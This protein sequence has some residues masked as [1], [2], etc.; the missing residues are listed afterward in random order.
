MKKKINPLFLSTLFT[1]GIVTSISTVFVPKALASCTDRGLGSATATYTFSAAGNKQVWLRMAGTTASSKRINVETRNANGATSCLLA[2]NEAPTT[3]WRWVRA[4]GASGQF[5]ATT[6]NTVVIYGLD[7]GVRVDRLIAFDAARSCTPSNAIGSTLGNE[8]LD[9]ATPPPP[10]PPAPDTTAPVGPSSLTATAASQT[11][12]NLSWPAATDNVGVV[13]YEIFRNNTLINT[14]SNT[15]RSVSDSNDVKA[16]TSYTYRVIAK[17]AAGNASTGSQTIVSTPQPVATAPSAPTN[18]TTGLAFNPWSR[19]YYVDLRWTP[20]TTKTG[21]QYEVIRDGVSVG[22][23]SATNYQDSNIR[24]NTFYTY[25]VRAI[26][27]TLQSPLSAST[28]IVGRC[29][30]W[31]CWKG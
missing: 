14:V 19:A 20:T 1:L 2:N 27:G 15:V 31:F 25:Q 10:P 13:S 23:V 21:I 30:L 29:F 3:D 22:R 16:A 18:L 9:P 5:A 11:Q 8:C 24:P 7:A 17:D 12:I 28:T 26:D 6:S 4:G